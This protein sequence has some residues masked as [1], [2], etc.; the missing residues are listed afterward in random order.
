MNLVTTLFSSMFTDSVPSMQ[1]W[2][3]TA[4]YLPLLSLSMGAELE[5]ELDVAGT[6]DG[7]TNPALEL[8]TPLPLLLVALHWTRSE[9]RGATETRCVHALEPAPLVW[10]GHVDAA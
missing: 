9:R 8:L 7:A 3:P 1:G 6:S 4:R 10:R 5:L 2:Q